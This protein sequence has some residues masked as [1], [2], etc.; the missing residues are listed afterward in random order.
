MKH[1][2]L[3]WRTGT[4]DA[5]SE[6]MS[7]IR[8]ALMAALT[9][10]ALASCYQESAYA[11]PSY[12]QP[13]E[14]NGP[15]GGE[16]DPYGGQPQPAP[17]P[18]PAQAEYGGVNYGDVNAGYDPSA[19]VADPSAQQAYVDPN[20]PNAQAAVDPNAAQDPNATGPVTDAQIDA[21]LDGYGSW[22]S[23]ADYGQVWYPN[24]SV[25]GVDFTPYE[26][27]GS[28]VWSD[29]GWMYNCDYSWGW[30]PFHYGR[31]GWFNGRWG[32]VRGYQW[33]PAWVDWRYGGG[34]VGWRPMFPGNWQIRD[35]R[36]YDSQWRFASQGDFGRGHIRGHLF[37]N[38]A[39]GL[40]VTS[41]VARPPLRGI[42]QPVRAATLMP[43][44]RP[45]MSYGSRPMSARA[46]QAFHPAQPTW[47]QPMPAQPA[48]RQPMPAYR[49]PMQPAYR[50]PM[51]PA[52]RQP[53]PAQPAYRQPMQP[54]YRP[55]APTYRQPM[56]PTYRAPAPTYRPPAPMYRAPVQTF[57]PAAPSRS[58][59]APS[60]SFSAP[61]RSFSAPSHSFSGGGGSFHSSGGGGFHSSGGGGRHR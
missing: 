60:R 33:S 36:H 30:L 10:G 55:P 5:H 2:G 52:Y 46:P 45:A 22:E 47:H 43:R 58:F 9:L 25:V 49:Q 7:T 20:D 1:A 21:T 29:S 26:T 41:T 6:R 17:A 19:Q 13:Q 53:M 57:H 4:V 8:T 14:V 39:E 15:P 37:S 42:S 12:P 48:Y 28:W 44:V 31:W 23:D 16:M 56:Q 35:H 40:R 24:T 59:S 34:Y 3:R 54:T 50:Q 51:Q 11:Q 27:C 38:P 61:S 32:W 18:Q